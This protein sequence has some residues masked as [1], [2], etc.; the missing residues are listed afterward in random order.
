MKLKLL[1]ITLVMGLFIVTGSV[2]NAQ[3]LVDKVKLDSVEKITGIEAINVDSPT[4]FTETLR[5]GSK[6]QNVRALQE[7]L[8]EFG[9][10]D[11]LL[12]S[13]YGPATVAA[14]RRFQST[15]GLNPDG[16]AGPKTFAGILSSVGKGTTPIDSGSVFCGAAYQ[17][18]C[19][20][21]DGSQKT[22]SNRCLLDSTDYEYSHADVCEREDETDPATIRD[23]I[24]RIESEI[25][26]ME[27][28][29]DELED[30]IKRLK[31]SL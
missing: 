8:R 7:K 18:V 11:K 17:P 9:F 31:K 19:G 6:S 24:K 16:I 15:H 1:S 14:V 13:D 4:I 2:A 23:T 28:A 5:Q 29:I 10:Y 22:F 3:D 27:I 30:K 26:R 12:D 25:R 20:I 21:K